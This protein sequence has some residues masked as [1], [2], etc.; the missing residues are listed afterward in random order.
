MSPEP[1]RPP[2][3]STTEEGDPPTGELL[4]ARG[5]TFAYPEFTLGPVDLAAEP[6][7]VRCIIGPNGSGK[8][9]LVNLL[10]GLQQPTAGEVRLM[11]EPPV[12]DGR[13]IFRYTGF[14]PDG[15]DLVPELSAE[16][17]WD[18]CAV[19]HARFGA[20][21]RAL[22]ATA[23]ELAGRLEFTPPAR[24][25]AQYSHGMRKKTQLVAA[26]LHRPKVAVFDEPTNG[27]DP[28]ASYRLGELV[29]SLA[30]D[31]TA[32]LITSHDLAWAER[33]SDRV[34]VLRSGTVA[35]AGPTSEV[36]ARS[37]DGTLLDSFMDAVR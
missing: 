8:T 17:L 10:L 34:T 24:P 36:L 4:C 31:G 27:L 35:A 23:R 30:D 20:S 33:F 16:E 28:I 29:R 2:H 14:C 9:T 13:D 26:L 19:L 11:G 12:A 1:Y 21:R 15:D 32:F 37:A 6:G 22:M 25:I 7:I 18:V 3:P 5:A